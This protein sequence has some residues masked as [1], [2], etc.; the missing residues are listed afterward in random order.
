MT[1]LKDVKIKENEYLLI[2]FFNNRGKEY[3]DLNRI[4]KASGWYFEHLQE[5]VPDIEVFKIDEGYATEFAL[6]HMGISCE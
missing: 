3:A 6:K 1:K 4:Q 2:G 5:S